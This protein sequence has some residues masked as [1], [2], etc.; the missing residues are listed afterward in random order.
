MKLT[1]KIERAIRKASLLHAGQVRRADNQ[2]PVIIHPFLAAMI[3]T[4]YTDDENTLAAAFLHDTLEDTGY[5]AEEMEKDFGKKVKDIVLGVTEPKIGGD[6][7]L[8]WPTRK[9]AYLEQLKNVPSES[10]LVAAADKI[11]HLFSLMEDYKIYGEPLLKK[12]HVSI[13][14]R[15]NFDQKVL[16]IL[17]SRLEDSG[18]V[19]EFSSILQQAETLFLK[20]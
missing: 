18:I 19:T 14:Q 3:L 6:A 8:S 10:L 1:S 11:H 16:E 12:F 13:D 9:N 20:D 17:K 2:T 7:K 5:S 4:S 15:L